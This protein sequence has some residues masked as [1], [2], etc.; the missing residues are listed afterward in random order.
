[1]VLGPENFAHPGFG[2]LGISVKVSLPGPI[3]QA[4]KLAPS[5]AHELPA[6]AHEFQKETARVAG[7]AD[8]VNVTVQ[9]IAV[10]ALFAGI[11]IVLLLRE[12]KK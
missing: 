5:I 3:V 9:T 1:M 10:G 12:K 11:G 6:Y 7:I 8:A 4:A 2:S